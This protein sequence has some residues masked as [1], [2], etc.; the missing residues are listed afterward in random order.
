ME[1]TAIPFVKYI[2]IKEEESQLSLSPMLE[3]KNHIGTIHASAQFTLAETQ[4]GLFLQ[5]EFKDLEE[6]VLPLLRSSS[7]K[8]KAPATT[9]LR[10]EATINDEVKSK[11]MEQF[12]RRGRATITVDVKLID[13]E[14]VVTMVGE[15]VWFIQK[16]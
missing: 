2:G 14:N 13:V 9:T 6:E 12:S 15:F 11:F 8:Y 10:A 16:R 4:S 1:V 3:V 5:E 7:V